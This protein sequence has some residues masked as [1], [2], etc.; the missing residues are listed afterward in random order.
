MRGSYKNKDFIY[1][2]IVNIENKNFLDD[3]EGETILNDLILKEG[4]HDIVSV[5]TIKSLKI[6][7]IAKNTDDA[8]IRIKEMCD[9]LRIYNPIVSDC[10][11]TIK[12]DNKIK[13]KTKYLNF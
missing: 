6:E 7:I 5:R 12:K 10:R 3:P 13:S 4:Y 2:A 1:T 11:I 9:N 8:K